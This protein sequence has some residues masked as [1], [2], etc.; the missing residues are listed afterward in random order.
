V[1]G[2][3]V[4]SFDHSVDPSPPTSTVSDASP[5]PVVGRRDGPSPEVFHSSE[6]AWYWEP[7]DLSLKGNFYKNSVR[8]LKR[9]VKRH[10]PKEHHSS[11]IADGK[12]ALARHRVNYGPGGGWL[13]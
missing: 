8:S 3:K 2:V 7:P 13:F 9:A 12:R 6:S 4:S 1:D 5:S 10:Y 11:M